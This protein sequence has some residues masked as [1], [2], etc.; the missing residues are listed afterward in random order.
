MTVG[1]RKAIVTGIDGRIRKE[2]KNRENPQEEVCH[3]RFSYCFPA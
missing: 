3:N 1:V 2:K